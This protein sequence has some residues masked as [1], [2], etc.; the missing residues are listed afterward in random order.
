MSLLVKVL[1]V[2]AKIP[3]RGSDKAAGYDL[4]SAEET[5]IPPR[6]RKMVKTGIIISI[7][8][9]HYGR[10][11]PRSGLTLK[12]G[13][14]VG[15]GVIDEDYRGEVCVILFNHSDENFLINIGD[16][17]A[18]LIL[19]KISTPDVEVVNSLDSTERGNGGF[20]STGVN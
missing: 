20:G 5:I 10:I 19:E 16:R 8:T 12:N 1:N 2:N 13:I 14:D 7:P 3:N 15:A 6:G 17:I 11:A 9:G 4:S 18:Q